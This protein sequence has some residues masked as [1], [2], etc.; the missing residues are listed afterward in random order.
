MA[1]TK[2]LVLAAWGEFQQV[3]MEK[4][5]DLGEDVLEAFGVAEAMLEI[6]GFS[7]SKETLYRLEHIWSLKYLS[8]LSKPLYGP[9]YS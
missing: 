1:E 7:L 3:G 2:H 6:T 5:S 8:F 4:R 9:L